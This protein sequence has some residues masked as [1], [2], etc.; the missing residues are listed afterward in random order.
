MNSFESAYKKLNKAQKQAV[1]SIEGPI[2]VV[3]GPGSGKTQILSL[4]VGKILQETQ[5]LPSNILCLTFTESATINMRKRLASFIGI[6]AYRVAI[7]TFHNFCVD[8][9]QRYPE[10]FYSGAF[11]SAVD[12]LAQTQI[13]QGIFEAL[14]HNHPLRGYHPEQGFVYLKDV[15]AVV[16]Y[17][18]KAGVL[19]AEFKK[20]I[21]HNKKH[22]EQAHLLLQPLCVEK[23]GKGSVEKYAQ[24]ARDLE[25]LGKKAEKDFPSHYFKN[26]LTTIA[27]SLK[28]AVG[29]A[30][31]TEKTAPL[32]AWKSQWMKKNDEGEQIFKD[33]TYVEKMLALADIYESYRSVMQTKGYYDFD[34]MILDV[35]SVLETS[36]ALRYEIQ[37]QYQYVL[38]DEFQDT[39]DAQMRLMRLITDAPVY[40]GK[41]NIMAVGDDDQAVYKFQGAELS[42]IL[43]F[44][45]I[46][47]DVQVVT[48]VENYRSTQDVLDIA[49]HII[50][51]GEERLEK[52]L[53]DIQKNL[54]ASNPDL[55]KGH[56]IHKE[57]STQAHEYHFISKEI[58][59][60]IA[61]GE[62]PEDIA[63]IARKHR[64]LEVLVPYLRNVGVPIRYE[65]EQ[66]V[67]AEP[68]IAE[69]ILMS[70]FINSLAHKY[71]DEADEL[72][73]QILSFPFWH[74]P[75]EIVWKISLTARGAEDPKTWLEIMLKHSEKQ[76]CDIAKFFIGLGVDAHAQPLEVVLD[77]LIGAHAPL[78]QDVETDEE[79]SDFEKLTMDA[80]EFVSPFK[81]YY[82][83]K[84]KF[85]YARAEYLGFLSSLRV[86]VSALR[87]YKEGEV[88][89]IADLV[90]FVDIHEKNNIALN[91]QSPFSK[92]DGAV[93]L[94]S[95]HKAKGLEFET[96]F[97][98]SCQD[99]VWAGKG[100]GSKLS[101]PANMP[102]EPAGDTQDDQLRLFYVALTRAK[103]F[104]YMTSYHTEENGKASAKLRFLVLSEDES[105]ALNQ[106]SLRDILNVSMDESGSGTIPDT[107]EVLTASWLQYHTAPFIASEE[108]LLQSLVT[109][110][111]MPVTHLN[112][113]LNVT[114]GGPQYF[115][116]QNL[117]RFPQAKTPSSSY[118]S[119]VHHSLEWV[120]RFMRK[121]GKAPKL[122]EVLEKFR[123][124]LKKERMS[125]QDF[126]LYSEKGADDV[127]VFYNENIKTFTPTDIVEFNFKDQGV[128]VSNAR[129]TGKIDKIIVGGSV[130]QVVDFKT[131][132]PKLDWVGKDDYEK[133]KMHQY[134]TQ[135]IFYKL[136][137]EGSR[138]FGGK[139][140][141]EKGEL[142][143]IEP[144]NGKTIVLELPMEEDKVDRLKKLVSA[145]YKKIMTVDFLSVEK[146]SK[147]FNGII[148]FE[149]DLIAGRI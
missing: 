73:P 8:I 20:I 102:I 23:I 51:K 138:E 3:A 2:L 25:V 53:P 43:N 148:E 10:Y 36:P 5:V 65:R 143:F 32:T 17:L 106:S 89:S 70:R 7:H 127:T 112:N 79:E 59:R 146:Y 31:E 119:A 52:I 39:N 21:E 22:L 123:V 94:L 85:D 96:V 125:P 27:L 6:E 50:R 71:M 80:R 67:F 40:E 1:D 45:N 30:Q 38:V 88:L 99:S 118:G 104:L 144:K 81:E 61:D 66:N 4:R 18:K 55:G 114:K 145:V 100:H 13:L 103:R 62:K 128:V 93:S 90:E 86:F 130:A 9:M 57:F 139:L 117:L 33:A 149:E 29:R 122:E 60:R 19:P 101:L 113:F 54:V 116:E 75:R 121:D 136:L 126:T 41:P 95:A 74:I 92:I 16:G 120:S 84:E 115:L 12:E 44:K 76:I 129:L 72:L 135:L 46:F 48:M 83:N 141:V 11:F 98:L 77:T 91:D 110:Y 124:F 78:A 26:I 68:H 108:K 133:T 64:Q 107:H 111:A 105:V 132:K 49:S 63:V 140:R 37:E 142:D 69:L 47:S 28:R 134:E 42:N 131:G 97:V 147:D 109:D 58:Q 56:I 15:R 87:E 137:V 34:D 24:V 35:I 82:F 14:P